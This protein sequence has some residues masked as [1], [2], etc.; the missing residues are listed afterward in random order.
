M[1]VCVCVCVCMYLRL[2]V[3]R[4]PPRRRISQISFCFVL[5]LSFFK[6]LP[7]L[8]SPSL[9]SDKPLQPSMIDSVPA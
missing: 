2:N 1:C 9:S 8:A 5:I 4:A 3:V 7:V 6:R